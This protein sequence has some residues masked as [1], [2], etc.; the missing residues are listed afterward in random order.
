VAY[1]CGAEV[2]ELALARR[3]AELPR[4]Q[5]QGVTLLKQVD[6]F[7]AEQVGIGAVCGFSQGHAFARFGALM[8]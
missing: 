8:P 5:Q 3:P 2:T 7:L 6:Q 4:Q 1:A